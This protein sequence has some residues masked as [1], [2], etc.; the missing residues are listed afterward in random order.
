MPISAAAEPRRPS[1][2]EQ[3]DEFTHAWPAL[4][5]D[6]AVRGMDLRSLGGPAT[7]PAKHDKSHSTDCVLTLHTWLRYPGEP[8]QVA[9]RLRVRPNTVRHR[10]KRIVDVV[11][12]NLT[13]SE[14]RLALQLQLKRNL[15]KPR[16]R[17]PS[18]QAQQREGRHSRTNHCA[19]KDLC[20]GVVAQDDASP[21]GQRD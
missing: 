7:I 2:T 12:L 20:W 3:G 19:G 14:Q 6:Q 13:D 17:R 1:G 21:A 4:A 11:D 5:V 16:M 10:L 9:Q 8:K 18:S 15:N